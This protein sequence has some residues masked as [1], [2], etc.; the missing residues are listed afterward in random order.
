MDTTWFAVDRDG[1]VA[2]FDSGEPGAVPVGK[3]NSNPDIDP[4]YLAH[5]IIGDA[6]L[7]TSFLFHPGLLGLPR[8]WKVSLRWPGNDALVLLVRDLALVTDSV[9]A[10]PG[11]RVEPLRDLHLVSIWPTGDTRDHTPTWAPFLQA[12]YS[13]KTLVTARTIWADRIDA[14]R[15]G[16]YVFEVN[17]ERFGIPEPYARVLVPT[18]PNTASQGF[19]KLDDVSFAEDKYVQPAE[20]I[21]VDT[22]GETALY[23]ASDGVTVRPL[24]GHEADYAD[25]AGALEPNDSAWKPVVF[26]PPL[27]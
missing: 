5:P 4:R 7:D 2:V 11:F 9:R 8:P 23:L 24:P 18:K 13:T 21:P 27:D 12:L 20:H 3:S 26:D 25:Q 19:T 22:W 14:A 6:I 15:R 1:H 16:F 10:L 17:D